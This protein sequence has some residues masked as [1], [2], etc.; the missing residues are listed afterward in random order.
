M[1]TIE[2]PSVTLRPFTEGDYAVLVEIS[3]ESYPDYGWTVEEVRHFDQDWK[4]EG[5]YQRRVV[6]EEAGA[7]VGYS[8]VSNSRGQ[9]VPDNYNI[10]LVVRPAARR[11]GI[12][13]TLFDDAVSALRPRTAHW[14]RNGQKESDAHSVAFAKKIGAVEL[15]RDWE[16]RLDLATFDPAP[17]AAA[18]KRAADAGVR[19]TT[20][21]D[22]LKTDPDAVR[23]AYTLHAEARIDVPSIDPATP[24]PYERFEEE[25]L[26][27]PYALPEAHF[28]AIRNGRYVAECSV[29]KEGTDPGVI[30][31]HLTAVLRDER[32]KGIAM[33]LKLETI[34]Y[35]K[36]AGLREIRT[37]NAS[38][39]RPMLAINEA[40]GFA[41]QPAWI[42]FGKDLTAE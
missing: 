6:A 25:V 35:A 7:P 16:S 39:N 26:R 12:G 32:G 38:I 24:S 29:G 15:K 21:A 42:T 5:Y 14:V 20:L 8:D 22:E 11:R 30:Y 41:K 17:F 2:K 3:N 1:T 9:F 33:A 40:L 37:W 36:R 23:K 34:D 10:D 19:I 4:P 27:S 28:L 31:Q 13:T 18:P